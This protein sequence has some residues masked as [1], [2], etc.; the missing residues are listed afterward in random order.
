MIILAS[1]LTG[2]ISVS[3]FASLVYVAVDIAN[4]GVGINICAT[5]QELKSVSQL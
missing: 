5:Q 1:T 4:S 3:A 2:C